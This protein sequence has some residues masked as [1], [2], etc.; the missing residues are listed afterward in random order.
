MNKFTKVLRRKVDKLIASAFLLSGMLSGSAIADIA[1][2]PLFLSQSITPNVMLMIDNS[3]SME[4]IIWDEDYDPNVDY[5]HWGNGWYVEWSEDEDGNVV[6]YPEDPDF[7]GIG[8]AW[9]ANS[10]NISA[11]SVVYCDLGE[12]PDEIKLLVAS[13]F[14]DDI[15]FDKYGGSNNDLFFG[16]P[17]YS[18]YGRKIVD[19][20]E[21]EACIR[22]PLPRSFVT[23]FDGNYLNYLFETYAQDGEQVN[24]PGYD[25]DVPNVTRMTVARDVA[26]EIVSRNPGLRFG[27]TRF[28]TN[29]GGRVIA[30]CGASLSEVQSDIAGLS[31]TT[32]TPLAETF[33]EVTRYFR[34]LSSAYNEDVS[35]TSPIQYRCQHNFV[36][37]ITDGFPTQDTSIPPAGVVETLGTL[38]DFD[39]LSPATAE[40][41]FPTD[42][43][44]YSDGFQPSSTEASE[45]YAL[46]MDDLALFGQ[47]DMITSGN[48]LAGE[49]YQDIDNNIQN[50]TTYTVGLALETQMLKDAAE[51]GDGTFFR[52]DNAEQLLASL[53]DAIADILSRAGSGSSVAANTTRVETGALVFQAR[54]HSE[55]WSGEIKAIEINADGS[56]GNTAWNASEEFPAHGSRNIVTLNSDSRVGVPFL[57]D[58]LSE[59]QKAILNEHPIDG[60]IDDLGEKRLRALRGELDIDTSFRSRS[61]PLGDIVNSDPVFLGTQDFDLHKLPGA[62]G[63]SYLSFVRSKES[64]ARA[65]FVGSN[66]G[67]FHGFDVADGAEL[68]AYV[69][70]STYESLPHVLDASFVENHRY[71]VDGMG[72]AIDTYYDSA[73]HTTIV[74][75]S[76]A[77]GTAIFALDATDP[78][79]MDEDS[80]LWEVSAAE[81]DKLGA[82]LPQPT[83]ARMKNGQ[84]V[85]IVANGYNTASHKARVLFFDVETG[86]LIREINTQAGDSSNSNGLS[87]VLPVD[88]DGDRIVDFV[89]GGDLLGNMWKFDVSSANPSEWQSAYVD[90]TNSDKPL[91]LFQACKNNATSCSAANR[92]PITA[93]PDVGAHPNGGLIVYFGTGSYYK[94]GDNI[95]SDGDTNIHSFYGIYDANTGADTDRVANIGALKEQVVLLD[96][97]PHADRDGNLRVTSDYSVPSDKSGWF[98]RLPQAGERQVSR[99]ILRKGR[100]IFTTVIP[101]E[102][103]CVA[104]GSSYL[105]ELDAI[106]GSRLT[107]E[108]PFD[109]NEDGEIDS[110]DFIEVEI[111]GETIV[112]PVSGVE[113]DVGIIKTPGIVE[114]DGKE[115]KYA[116]GSTGDLQVITESSSRVSGRLSWR[117]IK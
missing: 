59:D 45:G 50:I 94:V 28:N 20:V 76:G 42:M 37:A 93:R 29:N 7:A 90:A 55:D 92:Q 1:Q 30:D 14:F 108:S 78:A 47:L 83:I 41:D 110:S 102:D 117:Q 88:V 3:G 107:V 52:A 114:G 98:L 100:I 18:M 79:A 85:A 2:T 84:W 63:S 62:E 103:P 4:T 58:S 96:D 69:P 81:N 22:T 35:Y 39:G 77:G 116:S 38:P 8:G 26:S 99:P 11:Q 43:P 67:M 111:D 25:G 113:S 106:S 112:I 54:F 101:S 21:T 51:Y 16:L 32:N 12:D 17:L 61:S 87:S 15:F 24:E 104:G 86:A 49:S 53:Q 46:Y 70:L 9:G 73:W 57:W 82:A 60:T 66:G 89:Y 6:Y 74:G 80:V 33:Y 75:S 56:L 71:V 27:V 31:P 105:M 97:I 68:F 109:V 13:S 5:P 48:D 40:S 19:G 64:R 115:F 95:V 72:R 36:I 34:G 23:R 10:A 65:L 91:P 44:Q